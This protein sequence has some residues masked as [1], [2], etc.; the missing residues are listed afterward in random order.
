MAG[1]EFEGYTAPAVFTWGSIPDSL[2][3]PRHI[4]RD[5]SYLSKVFSNRRSL[6]RVSSTVSFLNDVATIDDNVRP[7]QIARFIGRQE[8]NQ[9]SDLLYCAEPAHRNCTSE[10]FDLLVG[11]TWLVGLIS[12]TRRV[13][14]TRA[15]A[16]HI[17]HLWI[18]IV[19]LVGA[20]SLRASLLLLSS[21]SGLRGV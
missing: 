13:D 4:S 18:S 8:C 15:D 1:H 6:A 10:L 9:V 17:I 19:I 12:S 20:V 21:R 16:I 11:K 7:C 14:V 3:F 2:A 5:I